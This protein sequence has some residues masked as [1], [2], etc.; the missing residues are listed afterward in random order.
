MKKIIYNHFKTVLAGTA[1]LFAACEESDLPIDAITGAEQRGAVL[2]TVEIL[3][4]EILFNVATSTLAGGNFTV[5]LEA[6]DEEDGALLSEVEVYFGFRDNTEEAGADNDRDDVLVES[7][8]ASAF[9]AGPFAL[10]RYQYSTTADAIQ[11]AL[12]LPGSEIFGGDQFT[13]RFEMVLTD[14]RRY[15]FANNTGTLTG[16]FFNARFL[17][18]ADI[19][20]APSVPTAGTW[21]VSTTDTYGDSWNGASLDVV[22]D[23]GAVN[24]IAN[25]DDGTRPYA[26]STQEFT[27]DV[28]TGAQTISIVFVS[29]DFD[30]EVIYSVTSANGTVVAEG[31]EPNT[32]QVLNFCPNNL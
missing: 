3:E 18:T 13:I 2:R 31:E 22:I 15:S 12:N 25:I 23:G 7:I 27:F 21:T 8:P 4:S 9:A 6:Q 1:L 17:H 30:S 19:V 24:S 11:T 29:G 14:G 10:P 28:P 26:S 32:G 5:I 20:C 16:A